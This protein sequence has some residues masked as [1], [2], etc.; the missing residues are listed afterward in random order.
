MLTFI[1]SLY[2]C[3]QLK[4]INETLKMKPMKKTL[5]YILLASIRSCI[6]SPSKIIEKSNNKL[7]I[8]DVINYQYNK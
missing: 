4:K 6:F 1:L 7:K 5:F 2:T 3:R 8:N